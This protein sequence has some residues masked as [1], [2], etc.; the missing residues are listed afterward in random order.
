MFKVYQRIGGCSTVDKY[1]ENLMLFFYH[2]LN[3][4]CGGIGRE[5]LNG[6]AIMDHTFAAVGS[7][8]RIN[9]P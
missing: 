2:T 8:A 3:P 5:L 9:D 4:H 1:K 6:A 7:L